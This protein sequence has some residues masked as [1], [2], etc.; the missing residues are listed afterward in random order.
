MNMKK[1]LMILLAVAMLP[2][3]IDAKKTNDKGYD[4]KVMSYNP[5]HDLQA[6]DLHLRK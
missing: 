2:V 3:S 5:L 4:L 1:I 6:L